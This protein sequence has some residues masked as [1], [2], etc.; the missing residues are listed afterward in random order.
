[1]NLIT[2]WYT[3]PAEMTDREKYQGANYNATFALYYGN[4]NDNSTNT[5]NLIHSPLY[6]KRLIYDSI[7]WVYGGSL[8]NDVAAAIASVPDVRLTAVAGRDAAAQ[9]ANALAFVNNGVRT[10]GAVSCLGCHSGASTAVPKGIVQAPHFSAGNADKA[11]F[12]QFTASFV[13]PSYV[14][15]NNTCTTC[16]G[17]GHPALPINNTQWTQNIHGDTTAGFPVA[18]GGTGVVTPWG[19]PLIDADGK[20][21]SPGTDFKFRAAAPGVDQQSYSEFSR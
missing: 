20:N 17:D 8:N 3:T 6:T 13:R 1:M 4:S 11:L 19:A 9:K 10:V 16:H 5:G 15:T 2:K 14:T 18:Q 12:G 7:D 21:V